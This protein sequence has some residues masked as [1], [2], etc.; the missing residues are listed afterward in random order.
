MTIRVLVGVTLVITGVVWILQGVDVLGG[1][2]M[3]GH[4]E[5]AL[6]GSI[7]VVLGAGV[8]WGA[9]N[10]RRADDD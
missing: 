1:S 10:L 4:G 5:W 7:L 9:R 2:G 3:S 8:L 6:F